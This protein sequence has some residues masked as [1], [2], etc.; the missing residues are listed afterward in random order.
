LCSEIGKR[1]LTVRVEEEEG[2]EGE[3]FTVHL[4]QN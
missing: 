1:V 4:L 3:M 2:K